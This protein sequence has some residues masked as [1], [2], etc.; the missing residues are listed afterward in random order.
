MQSEPLNTL[1]LSNDFDGYLNDN[2]DAQDIREASPTGIPLTAIS[3]SSRVRAE[4]GYDGWRKT[5]GW[6]DEELRSFVVGIVID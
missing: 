1:N 2:F 6:M 3:T 4:E 5:A